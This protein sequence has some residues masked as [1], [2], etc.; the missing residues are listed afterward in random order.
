[1]VA[2]E[3]LT[4]VY[5]EEGAPR[6][7]APSVGVGEGAAAESSVRRSRRGSRGGATRR[8]GLSGG[9]P[10]ATGGVRGRWQRTG[11][12]SREEATRTLA[13]DGG[14]LHVTLFSFFFGRDGGVLLPLL[15]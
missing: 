6:Q 15:L 14:G 9:G 2:T 10:V 3:E 7:R 12:P 1:L 4:I 5:G 13:G 8:G 11:S